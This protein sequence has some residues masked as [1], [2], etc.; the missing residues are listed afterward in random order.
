GVQRRHE[1]AADVGG[2][3][4]LGLLEEDQLLRRGGAAPAVLLRPGHAGVAGL[5][6]AAL[7]AGVVGPL[8]LPVLERRLRWQRGQRLLQ[9]PPQLAPE[10]LL[11]GR[12]PEPHVSSPPCSERTPPI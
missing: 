4:P 7:P 3:G 11:L 5:V 1:A 8:R 12:P 10:G 9:P 6:E 2:A